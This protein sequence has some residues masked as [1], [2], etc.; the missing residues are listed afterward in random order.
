MIAK[1]KVTGIKK[2]IVKIILDFVS[3]IKYNGEK[4]DFLEKA[5]KK[6]LLNPTTDFN[7]EKEIEKI[8]KEH[9]AINKEN[10]QRDFGNLLT[11]KEL[12][13][14]HDYILTVDANPRDILYYLIEKYSVYDE[15][16][17]SE[18]GVTVSDI[19]KFSVALSTI[20]N[21]DLYAQNYQFNQNV[22][23]SAEEAYYPYILQYPDENSARVSKMASLLDKSSLKLFLEKSNMIKEVKSLIDN[24]DLL[25]NLLSFRQEDLVRDNKLRFQDKPLLKLDDENYIIL[26]D[27]HLLF[28]LQYRL[29]CLLNKYQWYTDNKGKGFEKVAYE[30][31]QEINKNEKI[32]GTF[33]DT[34]FYDA[35]GNQCE[36]DGLINFTDFSW[37][38]ECKGRIP[39]AESFKGNVKSVNKDIK[40]AIIKA[41]IQA[42]RAIKAS[43]RTGKIGDIGVNNKKGILILTEGT[44]P[45]FNPNPVNSFPRQDENYP[46]Y[47]ISLLTLMEILRQQDTYYLK[48]FLEWRCDPKMP[49]YC[50]SELDYWDYFTKM[51]GGLDKK[52]GYDIAIKNHNKVIYTGNRF[53]ALKY[54]KKE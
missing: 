46:R 53:N 47:I 52:E 1:E 41:E 17:K 54:F 30:I 7:I 21:Y 3:L 22:F 15:S 33:Q 45:N 13:E 35:E 32:E 43:E 27:T 2:E 31:L 19:I 14:T 49:L 36:L 37:F 12:F 16:L 28:G 29:D 8:F 42:L 9:S 38:I 10:E 44:Y 39:R 34:I 48:Q 4:R 40:Q 11:P 20:Y 5:L 23:S 24:L 51:Q 26:N 25:L 50:M 18:I 6:F